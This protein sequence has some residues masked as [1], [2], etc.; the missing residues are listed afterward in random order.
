MKALGYILIVLAI[1]AGLVGFAMDTSV[2]T[3][4][5]QRVHNLGLMQEQ[6][7]LINLAMGG[8]IVGII[9][10]AIG[11]RK[12]ASAYSADPVSDDGTL[13]KCPFCAEEIKAEA[14]RC[15]HC[16][17]DVPPAAVETLDEAA[18]R[19]GITLVGVRYFYQGRTFSSLAAAVSWARQQSAAD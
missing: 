6:R 15:K 5:G 19:L 12:P 10:V 13:R 14:V 11:R 7:N 8:V 4:Y 17:A 16:G 2:P 3:Q 1:L 18:K 9:L